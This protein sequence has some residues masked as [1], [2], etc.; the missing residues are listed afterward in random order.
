MKCWRGVEKRFGENID[1]TGS[2]LKTKDPQIQETQQPS[3]QEIG[4]NTKVHKNGIKSSEG[5][6]KRK[7]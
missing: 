3:T 5:K 1:Q 6:N 4:R 7:S 2:K